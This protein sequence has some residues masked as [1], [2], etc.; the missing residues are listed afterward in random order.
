M[1]KRLQHRRFPVKS[2]KFLR[3]PILRNICE[4][5]LL[6]VWLLDF[7]CFREGVKVRFK[8]ICLNQ[9][10][11]YI[12]LV[13]CW[14]FEK[15]NQSKVNWWIFSEFFKDKFNEIVV[16]QCFIEFYTQ[17]RKG[18]CYCNLHFIHK[19]FIIHKTWSN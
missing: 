19:A 11:F 9:L 5:P 2:A 3:T 7:G 16:R 17:T 15:N 6:Y 18:C 13:T 8:L 12:S 10:K 14:Y 1:K 4:R